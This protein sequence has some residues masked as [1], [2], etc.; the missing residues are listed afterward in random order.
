MLFFVYRANDKNAAFAEYFAAVHAAV[1]VVLGQRFILGQFGNLGL[2]RLHTLPKGR[3]EIKTFA[4]GYLHH[5]AAIT[6]ASN[7]SY[8]TPSVVTPS[9][10][11]EQNRPYLFASK[12]SAAN[13]ACTSCAMTPT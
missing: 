3:L 9:I 7:S 11:S 8:R 5:I 12:P 4:V 2:Q 13:A 10:V 6:K 1:K